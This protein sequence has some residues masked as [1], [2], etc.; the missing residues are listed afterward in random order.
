MQTE[1]RWA[2]DLTIA[3]WEFSK[4]LE[5]WSRD[6]F[7]HIFKRKKHSLL[8][9]EEVQCCLDRRLI[10]PLLK[11]ELRLKEEKHEIFLQEELLWKQ[12]YRVDWSKFGDGNTKIF[13]TSI[14]VRRRWNKIIDLRNEV[15]YWIKGKEALKDMAL[16]LLSNLFRSNPKANDIFLRGL[17]PPISQE[18][19]ILLNSDY[20]FT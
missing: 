19:N 8:R 10:E 7:G 5:S 3:L 18:I 4:K 20:C 17:F 15:G 2:G 12:K 1:W 6:T 11:F 13:H 16:D 9:L 14:L